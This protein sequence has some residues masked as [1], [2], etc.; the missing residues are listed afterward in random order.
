[1]SY[2]SAD[3][4]LLFA[5]IAL[6]TN[7]V[8]RD[9]LVAAIKEW[10]QQKTTPLGSILCDQ[11]VLDADTRALLDG[12]V[13]KQLTRHDGDAEASIEALGSWQSLRDVYSLVTGSDGDRSSAT[14]A[15]HGSHPSTLRGN[16]ATGS[17]RGLT[18]SQRY[19]VRGEMINRGGLGELFMAEDTELRRDVVVKE[20]QGR[21]ASD[22]AARERFVIEAEI[23]G[24]LEH[25]GVVPVYGLGQYADGRPFYAM[26]FIK[27]DN[28]KA[29]TERFHDPK[30]THRTEGERVLAF[31]TLIGR[32]IDVCQAVAY[33]HSRGVLHRDLKP[34]NVMLGKYGET[35]VVDWG[36]AKAI[37]RRQT[38]PPDATIGG[39]GTLRP[40]SGSDLS[41]KGQLMG[42]PAYMSPEQA[43]GRI[44]DLGPASDVYSLGATLYS[45]LT[46]KAP[47]E[48]KG[49]DVVPLVQAGKFPRPGVVKPDT[50]AALEAVCLKAMA[51]KPQDRY[52]GPA[53]LADDLEHW[54]ADE[55]VAAWREPWRVRAGRW[56]RRHRTAAV[57]AMV[58]LAT[59]TAALAVGYGL[60]TKERDTAITAEAQ[61]RNEWQRAERNFINSLVTVRD[62]LEIA[63][64]IA[65]KH[66]EDVTRR[67]QWMARIA[68][69]IRRQLAEEP[70]DVGL[71][72]LM[73][74]VLR[75]QGN[76]L[77]VVN[78]L[79]DAQRCYEEAVPLL[80][81]LE[82]G[83][84]ADDARHLYVE[85]LT[86][87][88]RTLLS[89]GQL[90]KALATAKEAVAR[91]ERLRQTRPQSEMDIYK[92]T[93]I[94]SLVDLSA[95]LYVRG[96]WKETLAAADDA[97]KLC[98]PAKHPSFPNDNL[99]RLFWGAAE[100]RAGGALR[101]LRHGNQALARH[102]NAI[103]YLD[104]KPEDARLTRTYRQYLA[105]GRLEL[106]ETL[107]VLGMRSEAEESYRKAIQELR[108]LKAATPAL[109]LYQATYAVALVDQSRA[110][111]DRAS[112]KAA[113]GEAI[114]LLTALNKRYPHVPAYQ[115]WL[116]V[117][118]VEL[119]RLSSDGPGPL[120]A[121]A[122]AIKADELLTDVCRRFP[123]YARFDRAAADA[124]KL[125]K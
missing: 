44:D 99:Y 107:S 104:W 101:E 110:L 6:Q 76:S 106:G 68:G 114:A 45:V 5:A 39:D 74:I 1:M 52:G 96:E 111:A 79:V 92:V 60:V 65:P 77:R 51:L 105:V 67:K 55:P 86:D 37:G 121:S 63:E 24:G 56:V 2:P 81:G 117:A 66:P 78:D 42:T 61:T 17:T 19:Q 119:A 30:H 125:L 123:G 69:H 54:L 115:G 75:Y 102:E 4:N 87:Y 35:L 116:G 118:H 29:A 113:L 80:D 49:T 47:F 14:H 112:A 18:A 108:E 34:A 32:F 89:S 48:G 31:R 109:P 82:S 84:A 71:R 95:V 83:G 62:M 59:S 11:K 72:R 38:T 33:A 93:H 15:Q 23:T 27:G 13:D 22:A 98:D 90:D 70:T 91:I 3:R 100:Y 50:P 88:S 25:P 103:A 57:A 46:G 40:G 122:D 97:A 28:L 85:I 43:A 12:L 124:K 9:Q 120:A 8:T 36:L 94:N 58:L 64:D 21:W 73:A 16:P 26:R 53:E 10:A 7:F 41:V 20:I